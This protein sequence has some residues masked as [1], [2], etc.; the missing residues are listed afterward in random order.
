MAQ[1]A[2]VGWLRVE[3]VGSRSGRQTH[4]IR[5]YLSLISYFTEKTEKRT[6]VIGLAAGQRMKESSFD[7]TLKLQRNDRCESMAGR[8]ELSQFTTKGLH[9][10]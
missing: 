3:G 7:K 2:G 5:T 6:E 4:I 10:C 1:E 9:N 8:Y